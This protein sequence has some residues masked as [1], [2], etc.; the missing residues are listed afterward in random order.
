[1]P[2]LAEAVAGVRYL[3][4][5]ILEPVPA[6]ALTELQAALRNNPDTNWITLWA[7][8]LINDLPAQHT[9]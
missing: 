3:P 4:G 6:T 9:N 1:L 8:E 2:A 7:K 5:R